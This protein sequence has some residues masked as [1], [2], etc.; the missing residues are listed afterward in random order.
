M[1][2]KRLLTRDRL[3]K[4]GITT[5]EGC[6]LCHQEDHLFC[7]CSFSIAIL[8]GVMLHH[9]QHPRDYTMEYLQEWMLKV[10]RGRSQRIGM[11][12]R[13]FAAVL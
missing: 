7:R 3:K 11:L 1:E 9:Q 12:R 13:Q 6:V 10:G 5:D 4:M 8:R 2:R